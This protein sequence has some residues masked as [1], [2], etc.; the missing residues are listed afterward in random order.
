MAIGKCFSPDK[1]QYT[2]NILPDRCYSLKRIQLL[3]L[4]EEANRIEDTLYI[5]LL[6]AYLFIISDT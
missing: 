3:E 2:T 5:L 4:L 6:K 1:V